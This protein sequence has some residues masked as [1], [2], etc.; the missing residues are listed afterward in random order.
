MT[1]PSQGNEGGIIRT[2]CREVVMPSALPYKTVRFLTRLVYVTGF[3]LF[4]FGPL[5]VSAAPVGPGDTS[6]GEPAFD[7]TAILN[8]GIVGIMLFAFFTDR[9]FTAK[10]YNRVIAERDAERAAR[11]EITRQQSE[12]VIPLLTSLKEVLIPLMNRVAN[13][14]DEPVERRTPTPRKRAQ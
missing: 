1:E 5:P 14:L 4:L 13:R 9:V 8:T 12:Q 3:W 10:A 2:F 6:G 11:D 7:Y